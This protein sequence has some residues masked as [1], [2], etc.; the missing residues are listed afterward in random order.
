MIHSDGWGPRRR[1]F[2]VA[3]VTRIGGVNVCGMLATSHCTIV[4][5]A[6]CADDL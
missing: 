3:G 2:G 5:T 6:T 1:P 4:A